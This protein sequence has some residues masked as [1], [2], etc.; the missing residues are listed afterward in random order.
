MTLVQTL[1][2]R[3]N[4]FEHYTAET[5]PDIASY[6]VR[7]PYL[8]AISDR[9]GGLSSFIL[10]GDRGAGKSATRI[11][12]Y[13]EIWKETV[14]ESQ[15]KRPFVINLIDFSGLEDP[16]KKGTLTE[17]DIINSVA[18]AVIEQVLVW[19]SSLEHEERDTYLGALDPAERTL[20]FALLKGFYLK[21]PEMDR[22]I[23][24]ADAL[25][26]LN[27]AWTTKSQIWMTQ[28]WEALSKII[29]TAVSALSKQ[30]VDNDLDISSPAEALLKS[31]VGDSPNVPRAILIK[32]VEFVKF[33]PFSGI[34]VLIDKVDETRLTASSAEATARMIHP[35]LANIQLM[36]V[37][38]FCWI[39]F[40]WS[41]VRDHFQSEKYMVRLDKLAHSNILWN[42]DNLRNML[43]ARVHFFSS[44]N[45]KFADLFESSV[46][47][48]AAFS[49][50]IEIAINSP[51][52]LI[53]LMDT[54]V[55]EHD[56]LNESAFVKID[57]DSI[58]IGLDKYVTETIG[59]FFPDKFLQQV[60][61]LGRKSFVNRDVQA[62][63]KIGDQGARVKI[64]IWED[65]GLVRQS[66]TQ[67]TA[68]ESGGKPA[69]RF[70][71]AD[72]RVERI[73]DR[74]LVESVG[75]GFEGPDV[76]EQLSDEVG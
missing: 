6:A 19:L 12:V 30:V 45:L 15:K 42:K 50:L 7:P 61:R 9:V 46:D 58:E 72:A 37:P 43:E 71:I 52:E 34:S 1:A 11:T 14:V 31:L 73:I 22:D 5:E 41:R 26:L 47:P 48:E 56:I 8:Q 40:L 76:E 28:R 18:F 29:A 20:A 57:S 38:D 69:Y 10:F 55:R 63:F 4:P 35:L 64:K 66:G 36:E 60:L 67:A 51:R 49:T 17:K 54:I 39:M 44:G 2:L 3:G 53:K 74:K 65:V 13:N 32:L 24:N 33:F 70:V 23:A 75:A 68:S 27:G 16:F 21:V 25:R 62:A 59:G